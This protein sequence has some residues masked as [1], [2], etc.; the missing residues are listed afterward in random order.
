MK[1]VPRTKYF[2]RFLIHSLKNFYHT[3]NKIIF[4][5]IVIT[6]FV[7]VGLYFHLDKHAIAFFVVIFGIISQAFL[8]L[9]NIIGL[10]PIIGPILA[11]ILA[12]PLYWI[13]NG[14]GY[15]VSIFAIK[16]GFG[17]EVLNTRVLTIVFLVG[18]ALGF[19]LGKV[20]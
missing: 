5:W 10:V 3:F 1:S 17:K 13:L 15:F 6:I 19:V 12:L 9:I 14:L 7:A 20:I 16:K 4:L 2:F 8:G 11:K 18:V